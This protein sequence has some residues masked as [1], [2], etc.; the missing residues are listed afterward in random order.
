MIEYYEIYIRCTGSNLYEDDYSMFNDEVKTFETADEVKEFLKATYL[1]AKCNRMYSGD[2]VHSGFVYEFEN[3]DWSHSPVERWKQRDW[4]EI[5]KIHAY[6][7][8][9]LGEFGDVDAN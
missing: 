4:V 9:I 5:R 3:A 6:N 1:D 7:P 2:N 8:V